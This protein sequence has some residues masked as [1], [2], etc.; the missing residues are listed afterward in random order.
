MHAQA[1]DSWESAGE[2]FRRV[3]WRVAAGL[4]LVVALPGCRGAGEGTAAPAKV[5]TAMELKRNQARRS[6]SSIQTSIRLV[7]A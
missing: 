2:W 4:L 3:F 7:V 6:A 1:N 5:Q